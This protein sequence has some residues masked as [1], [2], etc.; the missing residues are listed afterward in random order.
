VAAKRVPSG[1]KR[2]GLIIALFVLD[3]LHLF[4]CWIKDRNFSTVCG[5]DFPVRADGEREYI[6]FAGPA[7]SPKRI[8]RWVEGLDAPILVIAYNDVPLAVHCNG[9]AHR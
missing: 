3:F 7:G 9:G 1:P 4:A 6:L 2:H 8:C 5:I